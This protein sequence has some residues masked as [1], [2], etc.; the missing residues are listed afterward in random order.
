MS[1]PKPFSHERIE[2]SNGLMIVLILLVLLA[3]GLVEIVPL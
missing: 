2:T 1:A 3:G